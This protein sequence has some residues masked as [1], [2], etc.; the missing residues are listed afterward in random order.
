MKRILVVLSHEHK[1]E[2][3]L[4]VGC[5][6]HYNRLVL[7]PL[8][9]LL[10]PKLFPEP[11]TPVMSTAPS[12]PLFT[13]ASYLVLPVVAIRG[14]D[15]LAPVGRPVAAAAPSGAAGEGWCH[16][17]PP[18]ASLRAALS[19]RP[20]LRDQDWCAEVVFCELRCDGVLG[21]SA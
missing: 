10:L 18:V 21:R 19:V 8:P 15:L 13:L 1:A 4:L 6:S 20:A 2:L 7:Q 14:G 3:G 5:S 12:T 11:Y 17:R 16:D 9:K